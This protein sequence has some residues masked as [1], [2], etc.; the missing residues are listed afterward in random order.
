MI[1]WARK[2][3][4]LPFFF[5]KNLAIPFYFRS[6]SETISKLRNPGILLKNILLCG[7]GADLAVGDVIVFFDCHVA[8]QAGRVSGAAGAWSS[9]E[10]LKN[11]GFEAILTGNLTQNHE[12]FWGRIMM[13]GG[14]KYL[15]FSSLFGE[16]I[17]FDKNFQIG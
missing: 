2:P 4:Y 3:L 5:E 12:V 1:F 16:M 7:S 13:D 9:L 11:V 15:L 14:F 10:T 8:P 6:T 17:Q